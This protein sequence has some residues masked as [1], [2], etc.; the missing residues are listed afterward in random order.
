MSDVRPSDEYAF[1]WKTQEIENYKVQLLAH[2]F[3]QQ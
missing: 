3:P 2:L 1:A